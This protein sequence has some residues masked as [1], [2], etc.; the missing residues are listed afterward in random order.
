METLLAKRERT[1]SMQ[2]EINL[3][4]WTD[5]SVKSINSDISATCAIVAEESTFWLACSI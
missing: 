3:N 5:A 2:K 1:I 4:L